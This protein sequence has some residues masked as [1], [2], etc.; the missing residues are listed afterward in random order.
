MAGFT[1]TLGRNVQNQSG[2]G[3][4][5][6]RKKITPRGRDLGTASCGT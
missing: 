1:L 5:R 6:G 4:L 3:E 2:V